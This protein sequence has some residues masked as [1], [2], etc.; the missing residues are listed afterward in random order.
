MDFTKM[1][2]CKSLD[3][4]KEAVQ[5]ERND[6]LT[7]DYLI[8][9]AP[10]KE[11]KEIIMS[12]RND[13]RKHRKWFKEIYKCYTGQDIESTDCEKFVKPKSY[14]EGIKRALFGELAAVEKYRI[15]RMGLPNR[16]QRDILLEILT[17]EM[18]HATKYNY[19]LTMNLCKQVGRK[20]KS[21]ENCYRGETVLNH[22]EYIDSMNAIM[23]RAVQEKDMGLNIEYL[24]S[25]SIITGILVGTGEN[26]EEAQRQVEEWI[27]NEEIGLFNKNS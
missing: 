2:L 20:K 24:L 14:V 25:K 16:Y 3:L 21:E 1:D 22:S 15:I 26:I 8:K 19:I 13:E 6:E 17:D 18:K 23:K 7:Y 4:I 27:E 10:T 9:M 12:I 5:D 11:E